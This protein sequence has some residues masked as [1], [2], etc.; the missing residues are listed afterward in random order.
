MAEDSQTITVNVKGPSEI[1]LSI[2]I[3]LDSTVRGLKEKIAEKRNDI[4]AESQR[5]IYTGKVLKDEETLQSYKLQNNHT[6]HMVRSASR[7]APSTGNPA[8]STAA[9][10]TTSTNANAPSGATGSAAQGVPSSF[11]AGQ[12]FGSDPLAALNR[13]DLAGPHMAN[14]GRDMFQGFGMNPNDPN[15]FMT[16]MQSDE[17]R[18]Q[19]RTMLSRPEVVDQIIASNPQLSSLPGIREMFQ[20]EQ[21]REFL[22]DPQSMARAAEFSRMMGGQGGAGGMGGLGGFGGGLGGFGGGAGAGAGAGRPTAGQAQWPPAGAFGTPSGGG[23]AAQRSTTEQQGATTGSP[24]QQAPNPF[25]GA[26]GGAGGFPMFDPALMQQILGGGAGGG[27]GGAGAGGNPFAALLGGGGA[28]G[29]RSSSDARPPEERFSEQLSQMQAMGL[30]DGSANL[31]ALLISGGSVE[32][33]M[34]ILFDDPTA[35]AGN[36]GA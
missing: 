23:D 19:M 6:V 14:L 12:A 33:A 35:G 9:T 34:S 31:R 20:N 4:P 24:A 16:A 21:F 3:S 30:T 32:G 5:L 15:M 18:N 1:K 11:G 10:G 28:G 13:A 7:S 17:F 8:S 2:E 22:L 36:A 27:A 29:N 25:G 26:G